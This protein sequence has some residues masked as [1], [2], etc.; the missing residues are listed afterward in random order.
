MLHLLDDYGQRFCFYFALWLSLQLGEIWFHFNL[1][2]HTFNREH[3]YGDEQSAFDCNTKETGCPNACYSGKSHLL[4]IQFNVSILSICTNLANT[5]LGRA[6][7]LC[8]HAKCIFRCLLNW[9]KTKVP[10]THWP[11]HIRVVG[12]PEAAPIARFHQHDLGD[13]IDARVSHEHQLSRAST[14][15]SVLLSN[16][17]ASLYWALLFSL[18]IS[19]LWNR[20]V[21]SN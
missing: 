3:V 4:G 13:T 21:G 20:E 14:I 18:S 8:C 19:T 2:E 6:S 16:G 7:D 10:I 5:L 9:T 1:F 11:L 17:R 12:H 15:E